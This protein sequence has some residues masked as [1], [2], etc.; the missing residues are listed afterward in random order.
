MAYDPL[1][2]VEAV[3]AWLGSD[4]KTSASDSQL[5]SLVDAISATIGRFCGRDNLG[6]VLTYTE[7]YQFN[8]ARS[9]QVPARFLLD[10]YP[11]VAIQQLTQGEYEYPAITDPRQLHKQSGYYV[12]QDRR[13]L[14]LRGGASVLN[15]DAPLV[16]TY[17]AGYAT[18]DIPPELTQCVN[19][20][21]GEVF[22]SREWIG[23]L[24][25]GLAGESV[26]F[27]VGRSWGMS[28]R[29]K[30]M[31]NPHVNRIPGSSIGV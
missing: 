20:A 18:A 30:A 4:G 17:T 21:I 29:T 22:K 9:P 28:A 24:S 2:T 11:I 3:K 27:D 5:A 12:E 26:T 19:Q 8:V 16:V 1:T 6:A 7:L 14:Q 23:Y 25:K 13:T 10:H 15:G 31:L